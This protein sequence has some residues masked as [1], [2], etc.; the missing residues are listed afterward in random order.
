MED[1]GT[2]IILELVFVLGV[3]VTGCVYQLW[4]LRKDR[5]KKRDK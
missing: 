1:S 2:I 5:R 4:S 3:V